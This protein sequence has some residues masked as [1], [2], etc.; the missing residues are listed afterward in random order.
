MAALTEIA[1]EGG[2]EMGE[3]AAAILARIDPE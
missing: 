2:N 3:M 1:E